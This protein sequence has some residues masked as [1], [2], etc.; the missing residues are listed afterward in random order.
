MVFM[1]ETWLRRQGARDRVEITYA[2]FEKTYIQAFGP[3]LHDVVVGEFAERGIAG[4]A[5]QVLER[6][7]AGTA[8]YAGGI[9]RH[10]DTLISFPPYVA[11]VEYEGLPQDDR[12]FLQ[13]EHEP[14]QVEGRPGIYAPGDRCRSA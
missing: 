8:H 4:H 5:E 10:F 7:E 12:G 6:V 9:T 3:R 13:T 2:T 1:L 11:A 14:R